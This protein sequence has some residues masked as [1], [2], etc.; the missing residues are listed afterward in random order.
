MDVYC[1]RN[2]EV[3]LMGKFN[4]VSTEAATAVLTTRI[5][6]ENVEHKMQL[7]CHSPTS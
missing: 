4:Y 5:G 3:S 1:A 7:A 2:S 6:I